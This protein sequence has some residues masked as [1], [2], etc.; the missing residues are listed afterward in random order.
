MELGHLF[1]FYEVAK[2]G[3]FTAAAKNLRISQPSL[4]KAVG[5]LEAREG[6]KLLE[7]SKLGV[8]VTPL[9]R[10]IFLECEKI[11]QSVRTVKARC[12]QTKE[13]VGGPLNFGASDHVANYLLA[14]PL[15]TMRN[16]YP[17][18][19]PSTYV[20]S[21]TDIVEK[22]LRREI[23]FGLFFTK[24]NS[25]DLDYNILISVP[26]VAVTRSIPKTKKETNSFASIGSRQRD[27]RFKPAQIFWDSIHKKTELIF[28]TNSQEF[29]KRI[30][31]EGGG[32]AV[33]A[34]FM[35]EKELREKKLK[36]IRSG[37]TQP[38][39]L[40]I[41]KRRNHDF[42]LGAKKFLEIIKTSV[43]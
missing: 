23:E 19:R 5:L 32:V 26:L 8:E 10:E 37:H 34:K 40:L 38:V 14:Q 2:A 20:A 33:L 9:G 21:P 12:Q 22:L 11:F 18:V 31:L 1:Y 15:V 39:P 24:V 7:R 17:L 30:C 35:V 6:V 13:I 29:Q 3:S 28:E 41:V 43:R 25:S 36:E 27:Y 42:S 4:S 16:K